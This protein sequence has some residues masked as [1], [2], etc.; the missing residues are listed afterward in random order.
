MASVYVLAHFDDE[1]G[2]LPLLL[3]DLRDGLEPWLFYIADYASPALSAQRLGETRAFLAGLGLPAERAIHVGAG[4]GVMDGSV[5][6]ALPTAYRAL[7]AAIAATGAIDRLVVAAWEGGHADHDACAMM[8]I[9]LQ[10]ALGGAVPID[11][12]GLYNGRGLP[13]GLFRACAPIPE[14]GPV[15]R[16]SLSPRQWLAYAAAVRFFPSQAKTWL[17]LWPSMF[18]TFILQRGFAYQAL[19]PERVR[20]RPHAGPLLYERL[21]KTPYE[22]VR[23]RLDAFDAAAG[24][25]PISA[26]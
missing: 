24:N 17:G 4:T 23:A 2:A 14:N 1:Y 8:T 5:F 11:Q 10:R 12:F 13:G 20:Q 25:G 21:F 26:A 9:A 3:R 16:L 22:Q 7:Q 15:S 19:T 18:M 6:Q